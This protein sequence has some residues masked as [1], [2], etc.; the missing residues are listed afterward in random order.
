MEHVK[1]HVSPGAHSP[2]P[3]GAKMDDQLQENN[4]YFR[5]ILLRL[6]FAAYGWDDQLDGVLERLQDKLRG[7]K[8][9][10]ELKQISETLYRV[11]MQATDDRAASPA[12]L[13]RMLS[14]FF[15]QLQLPEEQQKPWQRLIRESQQARTEAEIADI[16]ETCQAL[17]KDALQNRQ[18]NKSRGLLS[19]LFSSEDRGRTLHN[20]LPHEINE[21]LLHLLDG[22]CP[23]PELEVEVDALTQTLTDELELDQIPKVLDDIGDLIHHIRSIVNR[24]Q[25]GL[26][27]F[28]G[29]LMG[30]LGAIDG[31]LA[32]SD[33]SHQAVNEH[34]HKLEEDIQHQTSHMETQARSATNLNQL[35]QLVQERVETIR[36]RMDEFQQQE[37][38]LQEAAD[39]KMEQ[40]AQRLH[41][42]EE[43]TRSLREKVNEERMLAFNDALTGVPNRLAYE[44]RLAQEYARWKRYQTPL[45]TL[46]VDIDHF[47]RI[48]DNYGHRSGDKALKII[49]GELKRMIRETDLL[50]RYGGEE[51]VVLMPET[52]VEDA[53]TTADK[54]RRV[55]EKC[56]FHFRDK[57]VT[58]TVSCGV[59]EYHPGDDPED[60]FERADSALYEAKRNGRN[61]CAA[62]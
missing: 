54:L 38:Q 57:K 39:E 36:N 26:E 50:A 20:V 34:R 46:V 27:D 49:A 31:A 22:L 6:S 11:L 62:G 30:R 17:L 5:D 41:E 42:A 52:G 60:A 7:N 2:A 56:G 55:V 28:L 35:K 24:E 10:P 40:L 1:A 18:T 15:S 23:P 14:N 19:S 8:Q 44:E 61:Q 3:D 37:Q 58:I 13:R 16:L 48:N 47:K 33:A 53:L 59:S 25:K 4:Q 51:F 12:S 43:E 9:L 29:Q 45:S 21:K 32:E